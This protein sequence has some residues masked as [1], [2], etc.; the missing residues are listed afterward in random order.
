MK[1]TAVVVTYNPPGEFAGHLAAWMS[2]VDKLVIVD[3][4]SPAAWRDE[5]CRLAE[6]RFA[7]VECIWNEANLGIAASINRGFARLIEEGH[8]TAFIFDQDSQPSPGMVAELS[9]VYARHA[10]RD[11]LAIVAPN[12]DI[13]SSNNS[14]SFLQANGPFLF[15]RV[16][17]TGQG[18]LENITTVITSGALYDLRAYRQIGPFREDF[19]IDYVDTEYCLRARQHGYNIVVACRAR[20][21]HQFGDQKE[22]RFGPVTM[23]PSFHS[24]LRW[25]YISRNRI[26]VTRTYAI[27]F[28]HWFLYEF[29]LNL[30]G[31]VRLVLF[32]DHKAAKLRAMLLGTWDGLRDRLGPASP[33]RQAAFAPGE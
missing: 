20:L 17:C 3:N 4:G 1:T 31:L 25:Y 21:Q 15:R 14:L 27:Q 7:G 2:Q 23:H 19:F 32:E 5:V 12:I 11:R 26:P 33:A 22:M 24:P 10:D 9:D 29:V 18:T 16:C 30:Y 13:P 28:P 8:D 6:R